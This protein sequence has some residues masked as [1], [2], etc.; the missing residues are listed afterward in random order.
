MQKKVAPMSYLLT[1]Y[2]EGTDYRPSRIDLSIPTEATPGLWEL[3]RQS[4][5][6]PARVPGALR[7]GLWN[8]VRCSSTVVERFCNCFIFVLRA[9][10]LSFLF[11]CEMPQSFHTINSVGCD[12]LAGDARL[13]ADL[14]MTSDQTRLLVIR[15]M[16]ELL[17]TAISYSAFTSVSS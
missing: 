6:I 9:I 11:R 1:E 4:C 17:N 2:A 7:R 16:A 13:A 8:A 10:F 3:P 5:Q 14:L 15:V 12:P